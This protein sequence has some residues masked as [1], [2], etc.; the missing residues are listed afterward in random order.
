MVYIIIIIVI[1][2]SQITFNNYYPGFIILITLT[3]RIPSTVDLASIC[4]NTEMKKH[5]LVNA[6]VLQINSQISHFN[7]LVYGI[8]V[9][10]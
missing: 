6:Y 10:G 1:I 8:S 7:L 3:S 4:Q 9:Y 5:P 2:I